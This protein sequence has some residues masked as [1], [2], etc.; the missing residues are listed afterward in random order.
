MGADSIRRG[1]EFMKMR[2]VLKLVGGVVPLAVVHLGIAQ[3]SCEA[4]KK[5]ELDHGEVVSAKW[6]EAVMIQVQL[7]YPT[8]CDDGSQ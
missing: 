8:T 2:M 1:R 3:N 6:V 4:L 7:G 5:I